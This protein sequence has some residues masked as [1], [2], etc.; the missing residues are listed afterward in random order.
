MTDP[1]W[2]NDEIKKMIKRKNWL[3]QNQRKS[4]KLDFA[5]L[6]RLTQNISRYYT[7][8]TKILSTPCA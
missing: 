1:P 7:L 6:N 3:F 5:V 8:Q 4:C 2:M